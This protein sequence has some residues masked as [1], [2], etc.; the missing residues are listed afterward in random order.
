M[1]DHEKAHG[2][3]TNKS[4]NREVLPF[5]GRMRAVDGTRAVIRDQVLRP[6]VERGA[7]VRANHTLEIVR[8]MY[9]WAIQEKDFVFNPAALLEKPG[10]TRPSRTRY[11]HP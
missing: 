3:W 10:G 7:P 8:K 2:R 6:I 5:L 9:N 11:L 1:R 4:L